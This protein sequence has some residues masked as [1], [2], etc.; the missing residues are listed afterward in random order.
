[1]A[2]WRKSQLARSEDFQYIA[3]FV[4]GIFVFFIGTLAS[5]LLVT[6]LFNLYQTPDIALVNGTAL[7]TGTFVYALGMAALI[8][9]MRVFGWKASTWSM[10]LGAILAGGLILIEMLLVY[11]YNSD[12]STNPNMTVAVQLCL[13]ASFGIIYG[14]SLAMARYFDLPG[15]KGR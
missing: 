5:N 13:V 12:Y 10:W 15:K 11:I 3:A 9:S 8:R 2:S 6:W 1:M 7:A 14:I 4:A